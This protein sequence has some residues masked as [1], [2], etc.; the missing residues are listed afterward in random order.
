MKKFIGMLFGVLMVMV[1]VFSSCDKNE[2]LNQAPQE[3]S[4][5]QVE[6]SDLLSTTRSLNQGSHDVWVETQR[7]LV[8]YC[9]RNAGT[10]DETYTKAEGVVSR[11]V[12]QKLCLPTSYMMAAHALGEVYGN[13]FQVSGRHLKTIQE[14]LGGNYTSLSNLHSKISRRSVDGASFLK[15]E[16]LIT[17]N[18][19]EMKVFL[20]TALDQNMLILVAIRSDVGS[21]RKINEFTKDD[22]LT[23][24]DQQYN[25]DVAFGGDYY[26]KTTPST[27][28][29]HIILLTGIN[30]WNTGNGVVTYLDP[31]AQSRTA[32]PHEFKSRVYAL[33]GSY[34]NNARYVLYSKLLNSMLANG[35][36]GNYSAVA[37]G[38]R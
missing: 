35:A 13:D 18:R 32:L 17:K 25:K 29:G 37:V 16:K 7:A 23:L 2:D 12:A 22:N 36:D 15:S 34:V 28:G 33:T 38:L 21:Y 24:P 19:Q 9:Q 27:S 3:V 8:H 30:I 14:Q 1:G 10:R 11:E 20:E 5:A 26:F 4:I 6:S 31:L